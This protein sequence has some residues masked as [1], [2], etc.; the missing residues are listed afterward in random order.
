MSINRY[1]NM[2]YLGVDVNPYGYYISYVSNYLRNILQISK[3]KYKRHSN[4]RIS[5]YALIL[6]YGT[7]VDPYRTHM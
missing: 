7:S 1:L 4:F 3:Y 6:Y 5:N 2:V